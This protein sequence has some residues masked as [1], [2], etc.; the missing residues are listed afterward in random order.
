MRTILWF[1]YFWLYLLAVT[2]L[3][4][5]ADKMLAQ[6][7]IAQH[8]EMVNR[9]VKKWAASLLKIAGV[10]VEVEGLENIPPDQPVLFISNHQGNFDIPI[11]LAHLNTPHALL[12]KVETQKIPLIRTWMRH[13]ECVFV[14]R[15]NPRQAVASIHQAV[16]VLQSGRSMI[17]FPEGTRSKGEQVGEFKAGSF[18]IATKAKVPL[19]P[20][21]MDGSYKVMEGNKMWTRPAHVRVKVL[22]PVD[23][24]GL[25]R[26]ES[27]EL[28]EKLRQL[29]VYSKSK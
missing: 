1:I 23:V 12:A 15:E 13:L 6:G 14:D 11:L 27:K 25:S 17:I 29:I 26:E 20:V 22:S 5:K 7:K 2:P 8:R 24:S 4:G 3:M 19:V 28:P 18:K 21:V 10:T 9:E 16:E